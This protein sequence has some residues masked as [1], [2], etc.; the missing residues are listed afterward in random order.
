MTLELREKSAEKADILRLKPTSSS[1]AFTGVKGS[2]ES[3]LRPM[4]YYA[5]FIVERQ[6]NASHSFEYMTAGSS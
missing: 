5:S 2:Q 6:E 1:R 4:L 3:Q